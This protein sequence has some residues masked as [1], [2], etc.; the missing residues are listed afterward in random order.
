MKTIYMLFCVVS[1]PFCFAQTNHQINAQASSWSSNDLTIELGDSVT[2]INNSAGTHNVNGTTATFPVNPESFGMLTSS[3]NW[4]FGKRFNTPGLYAYRCDVHSAMMTG[5]IRVN[6]PSLGIQETTVDQLFFAP[7][8][9]T[10]VIQF[11]SEWDGMVM[12]VYSLHG[13]LLLKVQLDTDLKVDVSSLPSGVYLVQSFD[14]SSKKTY[15]F[16][17]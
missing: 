16:K 17:K 5:V 6:D 9:A 14:D 8:P 11:H 2:W 12:G 7:N 4:T 1:A 15:L 13:Q 3:G 10:D